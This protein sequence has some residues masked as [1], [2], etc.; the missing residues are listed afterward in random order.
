MDARFQQLQ[1]TLMKGLVPLAVMA[2]KVGEAIDSASTF[3]PKD[4]LW[5]ALSN[6]SI[7]VALAN[8]DLNICRR[9][10]FK[11]D[12]DEDYKANNIS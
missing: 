8:H 9:D 7:L 11:A 2:G 5:E 10:M 4:Q 12:L 1:E 3:P 6:V